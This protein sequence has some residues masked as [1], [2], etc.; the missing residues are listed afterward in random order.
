M[1]NSPPGGAVDEEVLL[2]RAYLSRVAEPASLALWDFV[3][4]HGPV[5]AAE[6]IRAAAAPEPISALTAARRH[7]ADPAADLEAAMHNSTRLVV[8]ESPDWPHLA[9]GALERVARQWLA[10]HRP[11][12]AADRYGGEPA[13]P[14]ALWVKGN[15]ELSSLGLN[16]A[17]IVGARSASPYGEHVA[18]LLGHGLSGRGITVVSGGAYGIDAAAHRAA[19]GGEGV[20]VIVSAGGVDRPYP[21]GNAR[22]YERAVERGL[23]LSE[24]PPGSAPQR[25][26]FLSRNRLIAA[27]STGTVVVEAAAR[28]GALNT[29]AHAV[30]IGRP[31]MVVP[32]PV[33]SAMSVGCHALLRREGYDA[34]LVASVA[35]VAAVVGGVGELTE[36]GVTGHE[37]AL[38]SRRDI[39]DRLDPIARRVFDGLPAR[40]WRTEDDLSA[41]AAIAVVEV[42]RALPGLRRAGLVESG[43]EG[44]RIAA[45]PTGR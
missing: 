40:G 13:P 38:D 5:A 18:A 7:T 22:L 27:L 39:L 23:V 44:H 17:A 25:H 45:P 4:D 28:S 8:P 36:D 15:G 19:L 10:S 41:R 33:T 42:L 21:A 11:I 32:G 29:A 1:T 31:L 24:S 3:S 12:R 9:F 34:I 30:L 14:L 37:P 26:R 43:P 35:D 20:T 6:L 2:A 16:S